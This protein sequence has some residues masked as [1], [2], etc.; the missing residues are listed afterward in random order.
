[1]T[2]V[3]LRQ[4]N[5]VVRD[6]NISASTLRRWS[7]E[8]ADFL[9]YSAG[10]P[11]ASSQREPVHRRY[12]HRDVQVLA[13]VAESLRRGM[14]YRQIASNLRRAQQL[15]GP[16]DQ[17]ADTAM[18]PL[19][20]GPDMVVSPVVS[21]AVSMIGNTLERVIEGQQ[22]VLSSQQA[23]RDLLG[24]V[25]QDNFNLKDE[26]ARLRERMW[27]LERDLSE[28]RRR[29]DAFRLDVTERLHELESH[30]HHPDPEEQ[31]EQEKGSTEPDKGQTEANKRGCLL[32]WIGFR[33][34]LS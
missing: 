16:S 29:E 22:T 1:M 11:E 6:L 25:I 17:D 21:S 34:R 31:V 7:T 15:S 32:G 28:F 19:A 5:E 9:S 24:V 26:N 13:T 33:T 30:D 10:R 23:N 27:Q 20:S 4:P 3:D 14:T 12:T 18:V 2:E 8:F